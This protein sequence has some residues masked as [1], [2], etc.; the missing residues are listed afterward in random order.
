MEEALWKMA[1]QSRVLQELRRDIQSVWDDEAA[2]EI[3]NRYLDPHQYDDQQM[4]AA[5]NEQKNILDQATL[6]LVSVHTHA[7]RANQLAE[8]VTEKLR[9]TEQDVKN[10]HSSYDLYIHYNSDAQ[11][12]IPLVRRLISQANDACP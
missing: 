4:L 9:L 2:R 8:E 12:R 6:K 1:Q 5:L 7:L 10:A 11:S 3:N